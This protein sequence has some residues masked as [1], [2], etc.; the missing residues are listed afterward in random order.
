MCTQY[1][2]SRFGGYVL[3]LES[4]SNPVSADDILV[5]LEHSLGCAKKNNH[6]HE[7]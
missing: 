4:A 2:Q 6:I 5:R 3:A 1:V 7:S